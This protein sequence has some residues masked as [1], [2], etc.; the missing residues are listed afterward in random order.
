MNEVRE[1]LRVIRRRQAGQGTVEYLGL[2]L[3]VAALLLA[4]MT[5]LKGGAGVAKEIAA[6]FSA[7]VRQVV[8]RH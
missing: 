3:A 6:A 7:A 5:Q 2:L 4:V 1:V 8:G